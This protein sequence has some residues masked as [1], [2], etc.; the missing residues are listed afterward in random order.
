MNAIPTVLQLKYTE[1]KSWM[2]LK[3]KNVVTLKINIY[4][5]IFFTKHTKNFYY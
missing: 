1:K 4:D 2:P 3:D 5:S